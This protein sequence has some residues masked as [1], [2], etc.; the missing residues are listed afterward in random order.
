M[1]GSLP[2]V[3]N[4]EGQKE[5]PQAKNSG[6]SRNGEQPQ[7]TVSMHRELALPWYVELNPDLS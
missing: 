4:L 6:L 5:N 2:V 7:L 1:K 3:A